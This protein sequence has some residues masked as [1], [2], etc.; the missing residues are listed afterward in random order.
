VR[1]R[2]E[3][4]ETGRLALIRAELETADAEAARQSLLADAWRAVAD[5][6]DA[7]HTPMLTPERGVIPP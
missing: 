5:L 6:E 7:T 4:G 3:L 2:I 1:H